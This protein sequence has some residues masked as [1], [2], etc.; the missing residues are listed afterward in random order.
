M[1]KL[2][3]KYVI[4]NGQGSIVFTEGNKGTVNAVYTIR[5]NK[6]EGKINGT[7]DGNLLKGTFHVDAVAGLIEFT[8]DETGFDAKWKQGIEPGPMRG[9]WEGTLESE[10][11]DNLHYDFTKLN[12]YSFSNYLESIKGNGNLELE[13]YSILNKLINN[14]SE[15]GY[16]G[17][18]TEN[19]TSD[20][21]FENSYVFE[22]K[23]YFFDNYA[24]DYDDLDENLVSI[25]L[26]REGFTTD[27]ILKNDLEYKRFL[28]FI[29]TYFCFSIFNV[30]D[31]QDEEVLAEFV[32]S[33]STSFIEDFDGEENFI[34]EQVVDILKFGFSIDIEEFEGESSIYPNRVL[35][36]AVE[37]GHDYISIASYLI[38]K[39]A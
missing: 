31:N 29:S 21:N 13:F 34:F 16:L 14:N 33:V 4:N 10:E 5:G 7:L 30:I 39:N 22:K 19:L 11:S 18:I 25:V 37:C 3:E 36:Y 2:N 38:R 8:F 28:N 27:E 17:F 15:F 32:F 9:K 35:D 24:V 26:E 12:L 23:A 1:L 20:N 6:S